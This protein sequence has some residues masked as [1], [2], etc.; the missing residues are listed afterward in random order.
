[1]TETAAKESKA[2]FRMMSSSYRKRNEANSLTF[3]FYHRASRECWQN[4][5]HLCRFVITKQK[6]LDAGKLARMISL[7]FPAEDALP[8]TNEGHGSPMRR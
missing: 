6:Y 3:P 2:S 8:G 4:I 7:H 5:R 1:M